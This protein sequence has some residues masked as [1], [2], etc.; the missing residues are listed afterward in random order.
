MLPTW[1]PGRGN[2]GSA[3]PGLSTLVIAIAALVRGPAAL[4][5]CDWRARERAQAQAANEEA[6]TIQLDC[7]RG[8]TGWSDHGVDT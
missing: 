1:H 8:L 5:D 7:R 3:L 2:I 4:R 6:E